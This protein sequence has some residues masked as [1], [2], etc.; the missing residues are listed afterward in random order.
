M[1]SLMIW[2]FILAALLLVVVFVNGMTVGLLM[3]RRAIGEGLKG[4]MGRMGRRGRMGDG[5]EQVAGE[6]S[7]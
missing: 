7:Q 5:A 1:D 2:D 3:V 4:P 6:N